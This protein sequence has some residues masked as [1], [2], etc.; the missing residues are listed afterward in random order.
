MATRKRHARFDETKQERLLELLREGCGR[1]AAARKVGVHEATTRRFIAGSPDYKKLVSQAE[2]DGRATL[3]E[4]AEDAQRA[5]VR[6]GKSWAVL[7]TLYNLAPDKWKD[8]RNINLHISPDEA[9]KKLA[10]SLGYDNVADML[11]SSSLPPAPKPEGDGHAP[12]RAHR[13]PGA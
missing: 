1:G 8:R 3:I 6:A 13:R 11:M 2:I 12:A 7:N 5:A 9:L 10:D 4:E